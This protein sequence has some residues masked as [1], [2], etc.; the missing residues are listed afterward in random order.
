MSLPNEDFTAGADHQAPLGAGGLKLAA[1]VCYEDA[2]GTD[3]RWMVRQSDALVNV[4]NDAWFGRS[5]A[6]YQHFQIARMRAIEA[7]RYLIRAAN[8][9]VSAI[10]GPFGEVLERAPEYQA[11][12]F[13]RN[14]G[15]A[16]RSIPIPAARRPA[17]AGDGPDRPAGGPLPA[18]AAA[19][20]AWPGPADARPRD[21]RR[22]LNFDALS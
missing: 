2:Y 7:R 10:V 1:T 4:T 6:R 14:R 17:G 16:A 9:G 19:A 20:S 22:Y 15:A 21:R 13:A 3:Q 5:S 12:H 8:D 18:L 11:R